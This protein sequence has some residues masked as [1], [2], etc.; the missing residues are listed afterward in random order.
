MKLCDYGLAR[1]I[2]GIDSAAMILSNADREADGNGGDSG[3]NS[4]TS[5]GTN[6]SSSSGTPQEFDK[7]PQNKPAGENGAE[8]LQVGAQNSAEG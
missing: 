3:E 5:A 8:A 7:V 1:S 6:N 4:G 2:S